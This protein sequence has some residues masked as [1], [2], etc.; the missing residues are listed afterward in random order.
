MHFTLNGREIDVD[1]HP[2]ARLLDVLREDLGLTG[3]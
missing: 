1:T 3:T 2:M